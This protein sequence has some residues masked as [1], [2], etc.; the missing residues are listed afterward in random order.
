LFIYRRTITGQ[1]LLTD[2]NLNLYAMKKLILFLLAASFVFQLNAQGQTHVFD[3][4][5]AKRLGADEYGMKSYVFVLL[6]TGSNNM[7]QGAARD[8]LFSGHL[9]NIG[10]LADEGKLVIAGPFGDNDKSYR[11]IF[12]LNVKTIEEAKKLLDTDPAIHANVLAAELY[13]WYG[14]AALSEYLEIHNRIQKTN[15]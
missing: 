4:T 11:G 6:V 12:I 14:S 3:S 13:E 2:L 5:L 15:F 1:P 8:S 7:A 9:K 10:R